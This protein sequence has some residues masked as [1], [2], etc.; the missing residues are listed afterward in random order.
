MLQCAGWVPRTAPLRCRAPGLHACAG[1]AAP[2]STASPHASDADPSTAPGPIARHEREEL[3]AWLA[4]GLRADDPASLQAEHPIAL[5]P[6]RVGDHVVARHQGRIAAHAL[7]HLLDARVAGRQVRLGLVGLVYTDPRHRGRG[8]G[9]ACAAAATARLAAQGALVI[10]LWSDLDAFYAPLGFRRAGREWILALDRHSLAR[11]GAGE[12][13]ALT[14][15]P[16]TADDWAH[17]E[18]LHRARPTRAERPAGALARLAAAPGCLTRIA[19]RGGRAVAYACAGRGADLQGI[20]HEWAGE[21]P[22]VLA[23]VRALGRTGARHWLSGPGGD[24]AAELLRAAGASAIAGDFALLHVPDPGALLAHLVGGDRSLAGV[25]LTREGSLQR[26][27]GARGAVSLPEDEA[28]RWL[29]GPERPATPV[30]AL[31]AG[32][33]LALRERLPWPLAVSGFDSV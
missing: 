13:P 1:V 10:A 11:A 2:P 30:R 26:L 25:R 27:T 29:L 9:R 3:L 28:V 8:L 23:C 4:A 14:V 24:P 12:D 21:T 19:R 16:A 7:A 5:D 6:T 17:L 20:V 32:E 31:G 15:G 18:A 22:G 33:W